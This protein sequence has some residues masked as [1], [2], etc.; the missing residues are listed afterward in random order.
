MKLTWMKESR[1]LIHAL[2]YYGNISCCGVHT[3]MMPYDGVELTK[4]EFQAL[5]Y[6][7][8]H[9]DDNQNMTAIANDLGLPQSTLTKI[10]KHLTA[11][12]LVERFRIVGNKKT[13]ILKPTEH[14]KQVY[15]TIIQR[16]IEPLFRNFIQ[17]MSTLPDGSIENFEKAVNILSRDWQIF[18]SRVIHE[19]TILEKIE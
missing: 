15:I 5:E 3:T 7:C 4:H 19:K 14:G 12:E 13:V 11:L 10:T 8:E 1:A 17:Y 18:C 2:I 9:E 16:D 6:I